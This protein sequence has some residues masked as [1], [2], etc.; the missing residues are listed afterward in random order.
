MRTRENM[1]IHRHSKYAYLYNILTAFHYSK[2]KQKKQR[3]NDFRSKYLKHTEKQYFSLEDIENDI[4]RCDA[5][6]TGSDQVWNPNHNDRVYYLPFA[7]KIGAKAIAYAPSV[8]LDKIPA[9]FVPKMKNWLADMDVLSC[10]EE[11]GSELIKELTGRECATVLDP[12]FLLEKSDWAKLI[13]EPIIKGDYIAVYALRRRGNFE[14]NVARLSKKYKLPV[15]LIPGEN[16]LSRGF[17]K[18]DKVMWNM[19]PREF[20]NI[21]YHAKAVCSNS[22]HGTAFSIIFEKPFFT[23][24]H[25]TVDYRASNIADK[26]GLSERICGVGEI[27]KTD[28]FDIDI[29]STRSRLAKLRGDSQKYFLNALNA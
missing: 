11:K 1:F 23:F 22:F 4:P 16:P 15:V 14:K 7:H 2:I 26:L 9:D 25:T 20:L 13:S 10:R 8:G 21:L 24:S 5:F 19:G 17:F 3:F 12:V 28:L 27:P 18:A 29:E 6:V